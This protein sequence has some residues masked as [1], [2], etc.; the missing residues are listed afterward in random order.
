MEGYFSHAPG[1]NL[2]FPWAV[3]LGE[4]HRRERRFPLP[5]GVLREG[6]K[7]DRRLLSLDML[8]S[9]PRSRGAEWARERTGTRNTVDARSGASPWARPPGQLVARVESRAERSSANG[10]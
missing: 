7:S 2:A 10:L 4:T 9:E 6:G 5:P 8:V 3:A 1:H